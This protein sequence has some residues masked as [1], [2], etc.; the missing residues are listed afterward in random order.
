MISRIKIPE[1]RLGV[2]IGG[3][4]TVKRKIEH[5]LGVRITVGEE[6][7]IVG[8]D[9]VAVMTAESVV[10]AIGRG[11]A[12]EK[13][14]KL[15]DEN[16]TLYILPLPKDERVLK[17]IKSRIIGAGGRARANLERLSG[18]DISVYGRT[19]SVIGEYECVDAI[20]EA[21][22]KLIAGFSHAAV[23]EMLEKKKREMKMQIM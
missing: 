1:A 21:L 12:P 16:V 17:R 5:K 8:E 10:K 6:I 7:V 14:F 11:F 13:A 23:Y 3:R 2:L 18:T 19:V 20:L 4:G 22:K 9:A 15:F